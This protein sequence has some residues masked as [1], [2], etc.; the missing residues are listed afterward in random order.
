M[1]K[2]TTVLC[3]CKNISYIKSNDYSCSSSGTCLVVPVSIHNICKNK[4]LL[5]I[6]EVYKDNNLY[7]RQIKKIFTGLE[8]GNCHNQCNCS[9]CNNLIDCLFIDDFKFYFLSEFT[10]VC[11]SVEVKTQYIYCN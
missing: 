5:V 7:A 4:H 8:K 6:V 11:I 2:N 10:P 9:C 1:K 3:P